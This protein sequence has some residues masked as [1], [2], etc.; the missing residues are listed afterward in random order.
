MITLYSAPYTTKA[1]IFLKFVLKVFLSLMIF[2]LLIFFID[3]MPLDKNAGIAGIIAYV[4]ILHFAGPSFKK[5]LRNGASAWAVCDG[6]LYFICAMDTLVNKSMMLS[7]R[8][9][10]E[11]EDMI[12]HEKN[13]YFS[14]WEI[15]RIK[16]IKQKR[17]H[18]IVYFDEQYSTDISAKNELIEVRKAFFGFGKLNYADINSKISGY[19]ELVDILKWKQK[20]L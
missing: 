5:N 16:T 8:D 17:T 2:V 3:K 14:I 9:P 4:I 12:L 1:R 19:D 13:S 6:K 18:S 15:D 7:I 20:E 11:V 10:G